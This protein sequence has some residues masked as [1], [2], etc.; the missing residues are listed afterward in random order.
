G[1]FGVNLVDSRMVSSVF[2]CVQ[3]FG[4]ER[5]EKAG[6]TMISASRIAAPLVQESKAHLEC[7]LHSTL[8]VG[9]GLIV[10]GQIV[11]A[12]IRQDILQA[13]REERY[14]LLDQVLYLED[15]LYAV[16]SAPRCV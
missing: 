14:Q 9:S 3:W 7:R 2:S 15:G 6:F 16:L 8:E 10:C 12:A 13:E 5:I 11:S 4:Q 1:C